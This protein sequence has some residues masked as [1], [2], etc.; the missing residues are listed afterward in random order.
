MACRVFEE[1]NIDGKQLVIREPCSIRDYRELMDVQIKIWGMPGYIEAVTYHML[2]SG[3]RN[4]GILIGV[5]DKKTGEAVGLTFGIPGFRNGQLYVYSHLFGFI[6]E[7]RNKGLGTILKKYQRILALEKGYVLFRW[8]YDPLQ[9]A[10]AYFNIVKHGVIVR[11]FTP[12]YYGYLE[13]SINR[14]MPSD[15]F[16]AEW[17]IKS[18]RTMMVLEDKV[19]KASLQDIL[20]LGGEYATKTSIKNNIVLLENIDLDSRS[21]IVIVEIPYN[22]AKLRRISRDILMNWRLKLRELFNHYINVKGYIVIWMLVEKI[23]GLNRSFYVLW[24]RSLDRVLA[25]DFPWSS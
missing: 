7:L 5:F 10:N 21:D 25:G 24:R 17:W 1:I 9:S 22:I 16:E 6:P 12:N 8:T 20:N 23:N 18:R 3:H 2:I 14:G 4:G 11:K 15:R 19:P 13:D